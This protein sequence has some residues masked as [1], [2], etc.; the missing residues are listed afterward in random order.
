MPRKV[1][2][3]EIRLD[4]LAECVEHF[5]DKGLVA[6]LDPT[7]QARQQWQCVVRQ[8]PWRRKER[9]DVGTDRLVTPVQHL[10]K[11]LRPVKRAVA[12]HVREHMRDKLLHSRRL[13]VRH[14]RPI[15]WHTLVVGIV[16][17]ERVL[18]GQVVCQAL[19]AQQVEH[20][21]HA[22]SCGR[23]AVQVPSACL[24]GQGQ[25]LNG[26]R[27]KVVQQDLVQMKHNVLRHKAKLGE[28]A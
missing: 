22:G 25:H 20:M 4:I 13:A 7:Q 26:R 23:H 18:L 12:Q 5:T 10:D 24:D 21:L 15:R 19:T 14:D 6:L 8:E 3:Q 16:E 27:R 9:K 28:L 2:V 1:K 17:Q 11:R